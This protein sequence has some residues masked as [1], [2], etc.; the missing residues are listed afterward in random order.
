[1]R[2]SPSFQHLINLIWKMVMIPSIALKWQVIKILIKARYFCELWKSSGIRWSMVV[3]N[4]AQ[5]LKFKTL[6]SWI[7]IL[8]F[9]ST[10]FKCQCKFRQA[11]RI[12][13]IFFI[14]QPNIFCHLGTTVYVTSIL[15][16]G[17]VTKGEMG[18]IIIL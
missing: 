13:I 1:M 14:L 7:L 9:Y 4:T 17:F 18:Q 8:L 10:I 5:F 2:L 12:A 15:V 6:I 3:L 16:L 11:L